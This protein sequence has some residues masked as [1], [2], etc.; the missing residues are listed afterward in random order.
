MTLLEVDEDDSES[1]LDED[2]AEVLRNLWFDYDYIIYIN[3]FFIFTLKK[4]L[5]NFKTDFYIDINKYISVCYC[6]IRYI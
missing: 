6:L 3:N 5:F 2:G 1:S 4:V